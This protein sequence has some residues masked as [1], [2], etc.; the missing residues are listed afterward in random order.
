MISR[1]TLGVQALAA[2]SLAACGKASEGGGA[3]REPGQVVF[4][5]LPTGPAATVQKSWEPV[6]ADMEKITGLKVKPFVPSNYT[7]LIEAMRFKQTDFGW[8]S[9][10]TG[11]EAVRR[12]G[13][14]VFARTLGPSGVEGYQSVLIVNA[15][16]PITID[17]ILK[18]DKTLSFGDGDTISTS[19]HVVPT[20][21]FFGEHDIQPDKCFKVVRTSNHNGNLLAVANGTI[22]VAT[23][24]T[25][26]LQMNREA[27]RHEADNVKIIWTSL[28]LPE[29]PIIWRKDL[30]PAIK[31]KLRQFFLTYGSGDTPEAAAQ[32]AKLAP[33]HIGGFKAADNNHL[34]V[35]REIEAREKWIQA[36]WGGDAAKAA[37]A[38]KQ[39]DAITAERVALEARTRAPAAAQ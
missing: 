6:L 2:A 25:T 31:E 7:T 33:L 4:S 11:L 9:N 22:D 8:F 16:S 12:A 39:L 20:A 21:Y 35:V 17:T 26:S 18:C 38:K 10:E 24:N 13:G 19:G 14:E 5:I 37:E 23:G 36:K 1:R 27:G 32:R 29:D 15:K 30:D 34:L 28:T 3:E